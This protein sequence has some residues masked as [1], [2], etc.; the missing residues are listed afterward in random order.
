MKLNM[1]NIRKNI[2]YKLEAS[3]RGQ[4]F[5]N[6]IPIILQLNAYNKLFRYITDRIETINHKL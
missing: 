2:Q 4:S 6:I 1:E 3:L 5:K